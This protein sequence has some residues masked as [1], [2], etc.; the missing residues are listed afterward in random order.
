MNQSRGF[1]LT[2][3][4]IVILIAATLI[5]LSIPAFFYLR[6]KY[7]KGDSPNPITLPNKLSLPPDSPAEQN[8]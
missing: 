7:P 8:K 3:F 6:E 1:S 5:G 2:E 4:I